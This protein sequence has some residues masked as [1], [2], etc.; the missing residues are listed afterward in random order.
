MNKEPKRTVLKT[1]K[2]FFKNHEENKNEDPEIQNKTKRS[3]LKV[4][5][6]VE[7]ISDRTTDTT[8]PV[9]SEPIM[10]ESSFK[11]Q[12]VDY[13]IS[14]LTKREDIANTDIKPPLDDDI[15]I[16]YILANLDDKLTESNTHHILNILTT[17]SSKD[18]FKESALVE[19][20]LNDRS[21]IMSLIVEKEN[22]DYKV[23]LKSSY[24]KEIYSKT[25]SLNKLGETVYYPF[26]AIALRDKFVPILNEAANKETIS[27]NITEYILDKMEEEEFDVWD[28]DDVTEDTIAYLVDKHGISITPEIKSL[29]KKIFYDCLAKDLNKNYFKN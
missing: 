6:K 29:I 8:F 7:N 28:V 26:N 2:L 16:N 3:I 5:D 20:T 23:T 12:K 22:D 11:T 19:Y 10:N 14:D 25:T 21:Y 17:R 13:E 9:P 24:G 18:T 1:I 15:N 27:N 4:I